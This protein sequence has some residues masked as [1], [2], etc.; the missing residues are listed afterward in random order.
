MRLPTV[1]QN[2]AEELRAYDDTCLRLQGFDVDLNFE[3]IDGFLTAL[4][5]GPQLPPSEDWLAALCGDSLDRAFGDPQAHGTAMRALKTRLAVLRDQLDPE[6]LMDAPDQLRLDPLMS[7]WT[8]TSRAEAAADSKLSAEEAASLVTGGLWASGFLRCAECFP[9]L[10]QAPQGDEELE[11][12]YAELWAQV[13]ALVLPEG[14]PALAAHIATV[15]PPGETPTRDDLVVQACYAVQDLRLFWVDHA[16]R[17]ET[18]RVE[19]TPGRNDPCPCGS[20][21]KFKKC[22]G[23]AA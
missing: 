1:R 9:Q 6:A 19:K 14:D 16:P 20:G 18:R 15:Y 3:S 22:H 7:E 21:K 8:D 12:F 13:E 17:P 23:V 11:A 10:W 4:A 2:N 5:A